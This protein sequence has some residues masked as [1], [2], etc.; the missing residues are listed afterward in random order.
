MKG[1]KWNIQA[2]WPVQ[3]LIALVLVFVLPLVS[4]AV[5][6]GQKAPDFALRSTTGGKIRL[7]DFAGK[8]N[9]LIEFYVMDFYPGCEEAHQTRRDAYE[10]FQARDTEVLGISAFSPYAQQAFAKTLDLPYPL[11]SD[12]PHL[13]TIKKYDVEQKIGSIPTAKRAYFIV[14]KQGIVRFKRIVSPFDVDG[15][16]LQNDVLFSELEKINKTRE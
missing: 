3:L 14:D 4:A 12:F 11:L 9:V 2:A 15:P 6:V 13:K 1:R 8:K 7:S 5:E 16:Y 10:K